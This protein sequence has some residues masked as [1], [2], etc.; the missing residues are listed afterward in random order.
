[1]EKIK[2]LHIIEGLSL[3]G[4]ERRLINDLKL[5][6]KE[7]F[8]CAVCSLFERFG[9]EGEILELGIPVYK[10]NFK[11]CLDPA[12]MA[13]LLRRVKK[14]TPR[15]IHTQLFWADLY[16]RLAAVLLG[17]KAVLTTVQSSVYEPE[18][19]C[20]FSRKRKFLD[21][22]SG[23]VAAARYVAV[24]ES[25][26]ASI[27][28]RLA[29]TPDRA[30][31]IYNYV[32]FADVKKAGLEESRGLKRELGINGEDILLSTVGRL[33]PPKGHRFIFE[34]L[35][36]LRQEFPSL[37]LLVAGDGP[38]RADLEAL[39]KEMGIASRVLFLGMRQDAK[40]IMAISDF[41]VFP[42]LSEGMPL[43]L[44][45]AM[46]LEVPCIASAIGPVKEVIE[47]K[48]T[49][50]LFAPGNSGELA[51]VLRGV[52]NDRDAA[53]K[54]AVLAALKAGEKFDGRKCARQLSEFY[55]ELYEA[56]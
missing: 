6:D 28:R 9:M 10:I 30:R 45:E 36:K 23:K 27:I 38:G 56:M 31:V 8:D 15:I 46:A 54:A 49:G 22:V 13:R 29:V 12:G 18:S 24:S 7:R 2:V 55:E 41:F 47:D 32:D 53:R 52:L 3:G 44:L 16:G 51:E 1:M 21:R 35:S 20:L 11:G 14:F 37:K 40:G 19:G 42:T 5:L 25:V 34:A 26:R 4:A 33:N 50:Y 17:V 43:S 39:A 48:K